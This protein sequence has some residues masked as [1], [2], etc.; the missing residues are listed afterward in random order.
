M[1]TCT[2]CKQK[3]SLDEFH[4]NRS[5]KDGRQSRCKQC[6]RESY[7]LPNLDK[8]LQQSRRRRA[9]GGRAREAEWQRERRKANPVLRMIQEAR[10]RASAKGLAFD[11]VVEDLAMPEFCPILGLQLSVGVGRRTDYSP[12]IERIDGS[13]GYVRGNVIIISWRANRLKSDATLEELAAIVGFYQR[14]GA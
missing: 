9:T 4:R 8:R 14:L 7:Y 3:L 10:V 2:L 1:K 12:S 11:L 13:L 5:N 6:T